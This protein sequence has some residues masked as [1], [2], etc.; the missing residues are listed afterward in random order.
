V[1]EGVGGG[2][3]VLGCDGVV[4][5]HRRERSVLHSSDP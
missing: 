2:V 3:M 5:P 1:G 4:S